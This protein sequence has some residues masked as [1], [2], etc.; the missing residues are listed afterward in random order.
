MSAI[1]PH[2]ESRKF[3][4]SAQSATSQCVTYVLGNAAYANATY[5]RNVVE[6]EKIS[7]AATA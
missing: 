6:M 3:H 7:Y 4:S 1:D 5:V 2:T